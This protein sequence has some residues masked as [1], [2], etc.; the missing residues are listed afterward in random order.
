VVIQS[1]LS[2]PQWVNVPVMF[3]MGA[4]PAISITGVADPASGQATG[5]PGMLLS[6]FGTGLAP[7]AQVTSASPLPYAAGSVTAT[8][9]GSAAP[10][11]YVSPN[12]INLQIPYEVGAG[13]A[14]LGIN[15]N[16]QV[17]GYALTVTA[18]APA[19]YTDG[20]GA[21]AGNPTAAPGAIATLYFNG[22]GEVTPTLKTAYY[23]PAAPTVISTALP[24]SVTVGGVP[25]LIQYAGL[26]PSDIATGQV[27]FYIPAA[28]AGGPQAV[29]LTVGGVASAPVKVTVAALGDK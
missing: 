17:A 24:L 23:A 14:V 10:L 8:V 27:N 5:A 7:G 18:S 20:H 2:I 25:A 4:N 29:V 28:T 26:A 15:N 12:Q 6:V 19:I 22:G 13:P 3:V 11:L 1:P 9:N 21:L 16:G